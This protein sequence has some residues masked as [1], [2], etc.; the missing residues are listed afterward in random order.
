MW[1]ILEQE[2]R[3]QEALAA[4]LEPVLFLVNECSPE[5]YSA[6]IL[7]VL[8]YASL[9]LDEI[10]LNIPIIDKISQHTIFINNNIVLCFRPV[11]T[12]PK[13][14]QASVVLLDRMAVILEKSSEEDMRQLILPLLFH[15][16]ESNMSQIQVIYC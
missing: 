3:S 7:P 15:S 8:R 10:F 6:I 13:S 9:F 1:P 16:L 12:N 5:E 2:V 4:A 14:I 11:F